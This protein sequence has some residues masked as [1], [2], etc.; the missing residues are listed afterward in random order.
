[1]QSS[2]TE[3]VVQAS[4]VSPAEKRRRFIDAYW[5]R[6]ENAF[7]MVLRSD[8]LA[9]V[10]WRSPAVDLSC[11][12]GVFSFLHAGGR[13][14]P[15]FDVFGTVGSLDRVADE[16]ADMFD[17]VDD[18][19]DPPVAARPAY[20]ID[21]GTDCKPSL[22]AKATAL[23]FYD[24]LILHDH[25]EPLPLPDGRFQT[26]YC[27]A[28]YW[29]ERIDDFLHDVRRI[30]APGGTII[31][32]VKLADIQRFTLADHRAQLGDRWLALIDRGRL[33]TWPSLCDRSTWERRF[34]AAGLEV[35]DAEP[36]VTGTHAH[37]W[38]IGLRPIA[39]LLIKAMNAIHPHLRREI[40]R[41]WVDLFCD[42]LEPF[43]KPDLDLFAGSGESV[44]I[45]YVLSP[46]C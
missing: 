4:S 46:M 45:Q 27:N 40:K 44:E 42:L 15:H 19:Y 10:P 41:D 21:V 32:H 43:C 23:N 26:V 24:E 3:S 20:S 30:T 1:M 6:P 18:D 28:A 2:L 12:D 11:G 36:F 38:D 5:L 22:L 9:T 35:L 39:P 16:A 29:V 13:F 34:D 31:L 33:A 25:N 17:H 37:I 7:W 8:A 14:A